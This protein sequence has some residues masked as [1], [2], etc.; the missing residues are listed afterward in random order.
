VY[1]GQ[2]EG[3]EFLEEVSSLFGASDAGVLAPGELSGRLRTS[4]LEGIQVTIE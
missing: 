4:L 3:P 2:K 1:H